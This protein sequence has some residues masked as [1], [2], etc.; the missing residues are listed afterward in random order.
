MTFRHQPLPYSN[1][2]PFFARCRHRE[3][4]TV[5]RQLVRPSS[6]FMTPGFPVGFWLPR[7]PMNFAS[8][9]FMKW[10]S[11]LTWSLIEDYSAAYMRQSPGTYGVLLSPFCNSISFLSFF[12]RFLPVTGT[13]AARTFYVFC[14][15]PWNRHLSTSRP[16]LIHALYI[17]KVVG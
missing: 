17:S 2:A 5:M 11:L 14:P 3:Q 12:L 13:L 16:W 9:K 6:L 4:P 15:L 8:S 7:P 10:F 1:C